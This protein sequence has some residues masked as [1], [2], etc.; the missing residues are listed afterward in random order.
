[1]PVFGSVQCSVNIADQRALGG[2]VARGAARG[3]GIVGKR[4]LANAAWRF[5]ERPRGDYAEVYWE[6]IQSLRPLLQDAHWPSVAL[7]FSAFSPGVSSVIAGTKSIDNL[8]ANVAIVCEGPLSN[9]LA[10]TVRDWFLQSD[11]DWRGQI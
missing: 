6:R 11:R 5:A 8:A 2:A 9:E 4:P 3:M 7:R 1:M 10:G